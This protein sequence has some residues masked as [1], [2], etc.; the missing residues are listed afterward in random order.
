MTKQTQID[1][2]SWWAL[3]VLAFLTFVVYLVFG[4]YYSTHTDISGRR[5]SLTLRGEDFLSSYPAWNTPSE[6]DEVAYNRAAIEVLRTGI[7]RTKTGA[8]FAHAPVYAYFLAA[9]YAVGGVR[10]MAVAVPQAVLAA[11]TCLFVGLTA[12][13]FAPQNKILSS[14]IAAGLVTINARF[15]MYTAYIFPTIVLCFLVS[16]A[17]FVASAVNSKRSFL[18]LTLTVGTAIFVGASFFVEASAIGFWLG[19]EAWRTKKSRYSIAGGIIAALV[20]IRILMS[21]SAG[22][23]ATPDPLHDAAKHILWEANNPFYESTTLLSRW[24]RR[25]G[26][27]WTKWKMTPTEE[28]RYCAYLDRAERLHTNPATLWVRENVLQYA[29]LCMIRLRTTLGPYTGQMS[30]RNRTI[31]TLYWLIIFPS[32]CYGLWVERR[33]S[34]TKLCALVI[35]AHV[36]F[37]SLVIVEWYLRYRFPVELILMVYAGIAY[38]SYFSRMREKRSPSHEHAAV[39]YPGMHR[40]QSAQR[41]SRPIP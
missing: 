13:D 24:E 25:P 37:A 28:Q 27:R 40:C 38:A 1:V 31:S 34:Y 9:C 30:P 33:R 32:G 41:E 20:A 16:V 19:M 6:L 14:V 17:L 21:S 18:W 4:V 12:R 26:N 23:G 8:M 3:P 22:A 5:P 39:F 35:L 10:L 36:I 7:P 29:K 15:A 11:L 2:Y